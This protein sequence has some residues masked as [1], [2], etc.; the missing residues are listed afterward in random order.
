[1]MTQAP[2]LD[3][4]M[5]KESEFNNELTALLNRHSKENAS[6]TPDYILCMYLKDCLSAYNNAVN[7]REEWHKTS[8][9]KKTIECLNL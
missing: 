7:R 5:Q 2:S 9:I 1:M 3:D 6:N 4:L 8:T